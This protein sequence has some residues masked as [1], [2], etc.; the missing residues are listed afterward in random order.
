M[1]DEHVCVGRACEWL[2]VREHSWKCMPES[3]FVVF[4][5]NKVVSSCTNMQLMS[6]WKSVLLCAGCSWEDLCD[7]ECPEHVALWH[8]NHWND[9]DVPVLS[10][11]HFLFCF[12]LSQS[13]MKAKQSMWITTSWHLSQTIL[14]TSWHLT[15]PHVCPSLTAT[16]K[17]VQHTHVHLS[18]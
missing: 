15:H 12:W 18:C 8:S 13:P 2:W 5:G 9:S 11:T 17:H 10:G 6:A 3:V 4:W 7:H 14:C 16:H 1:R